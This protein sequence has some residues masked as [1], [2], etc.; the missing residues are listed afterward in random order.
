VKR[1][2]RLAPGLVGALAA[3]VG[4]PAAAGIWTVEPRFGASAE[5]ASNPQLREPA[6][7]GYGGFLDLSLPVAYT[8][9]AVRVELS[10]RTRLAAAHGDYYSGQDA[11]YFGARLVRSSERA[12][13]T[14]DARWAEESNATLEPAAG[15]LTRVDVPRRTTTASVDWS[16]DLTPRLSLDTRLDADDV[17][18]GDGRR[19]GLYDYR[20]AQ[21]SATVS[22]AFR[23]L[24]RLQLVTGASR[25]RYSQ[26]DAS[27]STAF[28]QGGL[29]GQWSPRWSYSLLYGWSRVSRSGSAEHPSGAVYV[30]KLGRDAPRWQAS[31]TVTRSLQPSGFGTIARSTESSVQ[32][33]WR[34]TERQSLSG[35]LR[36]ARTTDAF[37]T[38]ALSDRRYRSASVAWQ[39]DASRVWQVSTTLSWQQQDVGSL[40]VRGASRGSG[41]GLALAATRRF[42]VVPLHGW[43]R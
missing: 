2:A 35:T 9:D 16:R 26:L 43:A 34:L 36:S 1:P 15:T 31:A 38:L 24:H 41:A 23:E 20:D 19:V 28:V 13:L 29:T 25:Y 37:R 21:G 27:N 17:A 8:A 3:G 42:G 40:F 33:M 5:Y 12:T 11:Y 32:A 4:A 39:W 18:Y 10:P 22:Y 14:A 6:A 7:S 30:A